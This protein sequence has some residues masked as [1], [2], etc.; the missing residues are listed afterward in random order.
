MN[1]PMKS[2][3]DSNAFFFRIWAFFHLLLICLFAASVIAHSGFSLDADF[4]NMLPE[5]SSNRALQAADKALGKTSSENVFILVS[6]EDFSRAKS[7]AEE[8]FSALHD[9][10]QFNSMTMSADISAMDDV[11]AFVGENKWRF[12]SDSDK[13]ALESDA[14]AF[15]ENAL[16][17]AFGFSI[18]GLDD[19]ENDPFMLSEGI[20]KSY[21]Q[22]ISD[23]GVAMQSK[24]GVLSRFFEGKWY[25]MIR[26]QLSK[27]GSKLN[28]K[29]NAV[30]L[31][32]SVCSPL[33]KDGVR[34]AFYG[35]PFHSYHSSTSAQREISRISAVCTLAV[36]VLLL[37]F[38]KSPAPIAFSLLSIAL[39]V[40]A[41]L[42]ATHAAFGKI[43]SLTL[44]FGTTL[45]G[46]SIDYSLHYFISWKAD[47]S[48]SS[49]AQIRKKLFKGASLS[50]LST[51]LCYF[52]LIFAPFSLIKQMAVFSFAGI[53][54][55]YLTSLGFF[56]LLPLLKAENR[57]ITLLERSLF[58]KIPKNAPKIACFVLFCAFIAVIFAKKD[59]IKI[60]NNISSL[61]KM[62]GRLK[63][64][65]ILAYKVLEYSPASYLIISDST[66]QGVL[67]K[68][69]LVCSILRE[70]GISDFLSTTRFLPSLKAQRD[71][72]DKAELL[73]ARLG[74]QM[75][76]LGFDEA[77][78][79]R[80]RKDF[81]SERE[82]YFN[83]E[84][85][86]DFERVPQVLKSVI[87]S[88][89]LGESGGKY[90]SLIVPSKIT[91]SAFYAD[92][93]QKIDGVYFDNKVDSISAGLDKLSIFI[94]KMFALAY[95]VIFAAIKAFF[96]WKKALKI[97]FV[98]LFSVCAIVAVF[99]LCAQAIEFFSVTAMILVFGLGLDYIIYATAHS[100]SKEENA[101]I[102]LS[103]LTTAI[104]FGALALSSFVPVHVL[105]LAIF[106]GLSSAFF[107]TKTL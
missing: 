98:P 82:N 53:L 78:E 16:A 22:A 92:L 104:S 91:D 35:T 17:S 93:A 90:Y 4:M 13:A 27:M 100:G 64:D 42:C 32:Y 88:L 105:G 68:E 14:D 47:I 6:H 1:N 70:N 83:I 9:A 76:Y 28:S 2:F 31:I 57:R 99:A 51:L 52:L 73:L 10:P 48:L 79:E 77:S 65:T 26:A 46:S 24:D 54:S 62:A 101:A 5:S 89:W 67:E 97:A 33:E 69:E 55:T 18:L 94:V 61:Y 107:A 49:T 58:P 72:L 75:E 85:K 21:L 36:L 60:K 81:E 63:D 40:L 30:P 34:F 95:I 8:V 87:G 11:R 43:H 102:V 29:T 45:I 50:L 41:A 15:S 71:S 56:P 37:A 25:V 80:V 103:F 3:L 66:A 96:S 12:I 38:F 106:V 84:E 59:D 39:S 86:S 19:I 44:V 20:A 23:S 74:E 7:V